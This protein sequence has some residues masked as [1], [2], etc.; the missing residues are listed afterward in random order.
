MGLVIE[1]LDQVVKGVEDVLRFSWSFVDGID[2][3]AAS[4]FACDAE[5]EFGHDGG[6]DKIADLI[7]EIFA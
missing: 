3:V 5:I 4:H 2:E 1:R 7:D 6:K